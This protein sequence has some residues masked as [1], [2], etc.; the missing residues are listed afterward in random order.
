M[1]KEQAA[2]EIQ[3]AQQDSPRIY[4]ASLS[5]YN[6]GILH[7]KWI[8]ATQDADAI[9]EEVAEMLKA[10]PTAKREGSV[11]E[12]WA[13]HDYDNFGGLRLS[14]YETFEKVSEMAQLIEEHGPAFAAYAGNVGQEYATAEG[15]E[16]SY[17]GEYESEKDFAYELAEETDLLHDVPEHVQSYFDWD[18]WTRDLFMG[19]CYS[20]ETPAYGVWVFWNN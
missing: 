5:D 19:D 4:V 15:F 8:D 11:A 14:E 16:E 18:A 10:S 2:K 6:A 3:A 12:E 1:T 7:G 9:L 17:R 13:I 20:I